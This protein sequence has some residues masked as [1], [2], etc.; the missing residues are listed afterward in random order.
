MR[1]MRSF[2]RGWVSGG[3]TGTNP[4][5]GGFESARVRSRRIGRLADPGDVLV[6]TH[7][8]DVV[9]GDRREAVGD[10]VDVHE[11]DAALGRGIASGCAAAAARAR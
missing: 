5:N 1:M 8:H 4:R 10:G 9:A 3:V 6:G 2:R 11:R 7:E